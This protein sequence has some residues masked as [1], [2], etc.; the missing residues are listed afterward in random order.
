MKRFAVL[1]LVAA[2]AFALWQLAPMP[3]VSAGPPVDQQITTLATTP[4]SF[5]DV[6]EAVQPAVVNISV[7]GPA[8]P[9]FQSRGRIPMQPGT[10]GPDNFEDFLR[11]FFERQS[12][13]VNGPAPMFQGMGSGFIIDAQGYVVTNN[14]VIEHATEIAVTFNDGTRLEAELVGTDAKTDLAV[15]KVESDEPLPYARFGDS[16]S[17]RVGD[18]VVA[19]GNPFGLG[20]SATTGIV[21]AR[22]RDIQSGPFDDFLQIDAPINRGNSGGPLFD[23]NGRVIGINTAIFSP[24][25]GNIGIGFAIP[26]ELAESVI[27]QLRTSGHVERGWLGVTIQQVDKEIA[28]GL[29]FDGD[30]GALV[31]S[32][33][34]ESPAELAGVQPGDVIVAI[35]GEEVDHLK[36]LTR[37]VAAIKPDENV[38]LE[39][40][41]NGERKTL[42]VSLGRSP[43]ETQE[44]SAGATGSN[45]RLGLALGELTPELRQRF[46]VDED[47]RGALVTNVEPGG[48]AAS[49]GLRP[50]D[51]VVMVGQTR[52][53]NLDDARSAIEEAKSDGRE[54]VLVRI[55]RG[56]DARFVVVPFV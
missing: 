36:E 14:H 13:N 24:N 31:A 52:V 22:G 45:V 30:T 20:G 46:R 9:Q 3:A 32:V 6:I 11:R 25:G 40:W 53:R 37:K 51:V 26:S 48:P 54:G 7:T 49:R 42:D 35:D 44:V 38:E 15:L 1:A 29:G 50:G 56:S 21:S 23:L 33:L 27:D 28:S 41:R 19:I 18:W 55:V 5:A 2:S 39:V 17:T 10:P 47:V 34:P 8:A 4:A 12:Y 43:N 16:D